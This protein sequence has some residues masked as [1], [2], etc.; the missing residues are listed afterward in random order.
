QAM[1]EKAATATAIENPSHFIVDPPFETFRAVA[2]LRKTSGDPPPRP[3]ATHRGPLCENARLCPDCEPRVQMCPLPSPPN[4]R[5]LR[6]RHSFSQGSRACVGPSGQ[7]PRSTRERRGCSPFR[8]GKRC[9]VR[10]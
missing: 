7:V 6:N 4:L 9:A 1:T 2:P 5:S 8:G 3:P 10:L